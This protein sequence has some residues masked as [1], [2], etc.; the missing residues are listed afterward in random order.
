MF[1]TALIFWDMPFGKRIAKWDGRVLT[2]EECLRFLLQLPAFNSAK[3]CTLCLCLEVEE[4]GVVASAVREC[5]WVG[6]HKFTWIKK[7]HNAEGVRCYIYASEI[8]LIAYKPHPKQTQWFH[9]ATNPVDRPDHVVLPAAKDVVLAAD[10]AEVNVHRKPPELAK[11]FASV[12]C[13]PGD[14]ALVAGAGSGADMI[15]IN[16]AGV[17]VVGIENDTRQFNE[18]RSTFLQ[19]KEAVELKA[20]VVAVPVSADIVLPDSAVGEE[21]KAIGEEK[22]GS[23]VPGAEPSPDPVP[24]ASKKCAS[25]GQAMEP[26]LIAC[27]IKC[28]LFVCSLLCAVYGV[29]KGE[30]QGSSGTFCSSSCMDD[31]GYAKDATIDDPPPPPPAPP[32]PAPPVAQ[33]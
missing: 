15:G 23:P 33:L 6:C 16:M 11:F 18:L 30:P 7:N 1:D 26:D 13:A 8:F 22:K 24:A 31:L 32:P 28:G 21:K 12:H 19:Y 9:P 2:R 5:G 10:G 25:C 14:W 3:A 29:P 20:Q 17:N 4:Y 27:C